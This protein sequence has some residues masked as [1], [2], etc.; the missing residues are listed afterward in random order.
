MWSS[1]GS[2]AAGSSNAFYVGDSLS[3]KKAVVNFSNGSYSLLSIAGS[4]GEPYT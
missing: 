4:A 1:P 3:L 2:I